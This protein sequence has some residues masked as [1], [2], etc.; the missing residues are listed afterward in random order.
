MYVGFASQSS[1]A[2]RTNGTAASYHHHRDPKLRHAAPCPQARLIQ[3]LDRLGCFWNTLRVISRDA[4]V[5][6]PDRISPADSNRAITE[7]RVAAP[8]DDGSDAL[9]PRRDSL[10]IGACESTS[11]T[12]LER[13]A[14]LVLQA[15]VTQ[16]AL[17]DHRR[18]RGNEKTVRPSSACAST[19]RLVAHR[20]DMNH[21]CLGDAIG[22]RPSRSARV[23]WSAT[24]VPPCFSV[25]GPFQSVAGFVGQAQSLIVGG[26][27]PMTGMF[28][29]QKI[30]CAAPV[31]PRTRSSWLSHK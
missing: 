15:L 6:S 18:K 27:V 26:R 23:I 30:R 16:I 4:R 2:R 17:T 20:A 21:L 25:I 5:P 28:F 8:L 13:L 19:M 9:G 11:E 24:S 12:H 3:R 7:C 10:R 14:D 1:G 29:R 31:P 22:G